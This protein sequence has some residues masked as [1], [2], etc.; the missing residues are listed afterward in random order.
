MDRPAADIQAAQLEALVAALQERAGRVLDEQAFRRDSGA[1]FVYTPAPGQPARAIPA[2]QFA[3]PYAL[4]LA[5]VELTL[6]G[7]CQLRRTGAVFRLGLPP[8]WR[9]LL[10]PA[11]L[12]ALRFTAHGKTV[13]VSVGVA[14]LHGAGADVLRRS[15]LLAPDMQAALARLHIGHRPAYS[16][17]QRLRRWR[18]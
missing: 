10:R 11:P 6:Y 4:T 8:L 9:R 12:L 17:L 16:F 14:P 18:T 1:P 15:I 2:A 5:G 13:A 7:Y 3:R